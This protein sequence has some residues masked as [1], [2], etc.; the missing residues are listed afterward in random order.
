M[1]LLFAGGAEVQGEKFTFQLE[2]YVLAQHSFD[3]TPILNYLI[4]LKH[5][6]CEDERCPR[7]FTPLLWAV[8]WS[9]IHW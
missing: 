2:E 3:P 7:E 8:H 9:M 6:T 4:A 1:K 5:A